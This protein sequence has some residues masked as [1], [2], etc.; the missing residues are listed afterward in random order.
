MVTVAKSNST[1]NTFNWLFL[2][3]H[4]P[5]IIWNSAFQSNQE[6][7]KVFAKKGLLVLDSGCYFVGLL[8]LIICSSQLYTLVERALP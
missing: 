4:K 7:Y 1:F 6:R 3:L 5:I 8:K 2:I